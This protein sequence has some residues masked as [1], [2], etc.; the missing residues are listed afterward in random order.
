MDE[1]WIKSVPELKML[2]RYQFPGFDN[3]LWLHVI[4][5]LGETG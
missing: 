3:A 5:S 4:V 1:I 2:N